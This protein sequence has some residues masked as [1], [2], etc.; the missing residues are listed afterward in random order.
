VLDRNLQLLAGFIAGT[1]EFPW[2]GLP[3]RA[4]VNGRY[5]GRRVTFTIDFLTRRESFRVCM[6]ALGMSR[7]RGFLGIWKGGPTEN[8]SFCGN[9]I[10]FTGPGGIFFGTRS[11][12][13]P[14]LPG[15]PLFPLD[16]EDIAYYLEQL[17]IAAEQM[18]KESVSAPVG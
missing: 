8:T 16:R 18:E 7:S 2:L 9:R 10:Y 1:I 14:Y 11:C 17:V 6:E 12:G 4:E 3:V 5:K 15:S 13:R